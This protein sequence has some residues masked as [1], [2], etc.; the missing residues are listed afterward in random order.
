MTRSMRT[1]ISVLGAFWVLA[2]SLLTVWHKIWAP[3]F[4]PGLRTQ[5]D[6]Q[7]RSTDYTS[8]LRAGSFR[9]ELEGRWDEIGSVASLQHPI[10][11]NLGR[12]VGWASIGIVRLE[13]GA[14]VMR[15]EP[16]DDC[17]VSTGFR[18]ESGG[19]PER[20]VIVALFARC[21]DEDRPYHAGCAYEWDMRDGK[22]R[23]WADGRLLAQRNRRGDDRVHTM[24]FALRGD[25]LRGSLDGGPPLQARAGGSQTGTVGFGAHGSPAVTFDWFAL[26]RADAA[27]PPSRYLVDVGAPFDLYDDFAANAP[28]RDNTQTVGLT[29]ATGIGSSDS[30]PHA[31]WY[32]V[33]APQWANHMT[34]YHRRAGDRYMDTLAFNNIVL[35]PID[36][37]HAQ[38]C[39]V[40]A[41]TGD[42]LNEA[43]P[44]ERY[45]TFPHVP[46]RGTSLLVRVQDPERPWAGCYSLTYDS[47]VRKV[48]LFRYEQAGLPDPLDR[49]EPVP[50]RAVP[51]ASAGAAKAPAAC[52]LWVRARGNELSGGLGEATLVAATDSTFPTGFVGYGAR[53]DAVGVFRWVSMQGA[54]QMSQPPSPS[55][56]LRRIAP[57]P[58][59]R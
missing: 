3:V 11:G 38:E 15:V 40:R 16:V 43:D 59:G 30:G 54:P 18:H 48:T 49:S 39:T 8:P 44:D 34:V 25:S 23:L 36:S 45:S 24:S 28:G 10:H 46:R 13:G 47:G 22:E 55:G 20:G 27:P 31:P 56:T 57:D 4:A 12:T 9:D 26:D 41:L 50:V 42:L 58:P 19:D 51:L 33:A 21:R 2:L 14:L 35:C 7:T 53:P 6:G 1:A 32:I 5:A 17:T 37:K 29:S 52:E